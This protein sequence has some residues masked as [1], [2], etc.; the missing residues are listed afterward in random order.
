MDIN[1]WRILFDRLQKALVPTFWSQ[2]R[3]GGLLDFLN[4]VNWSFVFLLYP[5][6]WE[7][8]SRASLVQRPTYLWYLDENVWVYSRGKG[9]MVV[10]AES[11]TA[12]GWEGN[13]ESLII[14]RLDFQ[15]ILQFRPQTSPLP[16]CCILGLQ[17]E[18]FPCF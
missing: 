3:R 11:Q 5:Q 14:F 15:P 13:G 1:F 12:W 9:W 4:L 17:V 18:A 16:F 6:A 8:R 7:L 10:D 2:G